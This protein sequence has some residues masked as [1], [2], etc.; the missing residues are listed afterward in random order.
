MGKT[1]SSP[2]YAGV[3]YRNADGELEFFYGINNMSNTDIPN[4]L[5]E[6]TAG[7][8]SLISMMKNNLDNLD[9]SEYLHSTGAGTHAEIFAVCDLLKKHPEANID[10]FVVFVNY[11]KPFN[12]PASGHSFF[13]CPHCRA[14]LKDFNIL[15]NV[16]GF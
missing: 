5:Q 9:A 14:I 8:D 6:A 10:D 15:S 11:T 4:I 2:A 1:A 3:A 16:E 7:N 12:K 13:T